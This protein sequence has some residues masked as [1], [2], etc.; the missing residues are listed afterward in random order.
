MAGILPHGVFEIPALIMAQAAA[1]SFGTMAVIALFVKEKRP[2]LVP[3]LKQNLKYLGVAMLLM[4]PA[5]II[6]AFITPLL[7][8]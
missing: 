6:E 7:L 4:V 8:S 5:A 1:L 2:L 3:N